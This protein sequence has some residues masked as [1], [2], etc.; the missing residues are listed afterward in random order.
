MDISGQEHLDVVAP[1]PRYGYTILRYVIFPKTPIRR[2][3]YI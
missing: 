2:Y 3:T 1:V